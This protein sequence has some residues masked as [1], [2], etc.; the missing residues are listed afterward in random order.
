MSWDSFCFSCHSYNPQKFQIYYRNRLCFTL[1]LHSPKCKENAIL[2][3]QREKK[4]FQNQKARLWGLSKLF[5][6]SEFTS[7]KH[8]LSLNIVFGRLKCKQY[9]NCTYFIKCSSYVNVSC[10]TYFLAWH[11]HWQRLNLFNVGILQAIVHVYQIYSTIIYW[12]H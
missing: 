3:D 1:L 5:N 9:V 10:Y 11:F 12:T 7:V 6:L 2:C 4:K 8:L